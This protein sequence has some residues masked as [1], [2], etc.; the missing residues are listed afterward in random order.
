MNKCLLVL[1]WM[2]AL[3]FLFAGTM[4]LV[5]PIAEMTQQVSMPGPLQ[6]FIGVAE[7]LG[8]LGMILPGLFRI[9]TGLTPVAGSGLVIIMIGAAAVTFKTGGFAM[10]VFPLAIALLAAFVVYGR[11]RLAP[12]RG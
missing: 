5:M 2:L 10:S 3:L 7:V 9:K 4:K 8:G 12:T 11:L 1:Q 6:R